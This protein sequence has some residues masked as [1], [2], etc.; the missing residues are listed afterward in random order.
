MTGLD[1]TYGCVYSDA[2]HCMHIHVSL[3]ERGSVVDLKHLQIFVAVADEGSI[4]A[5]GRKMLLSQPALSQAL[6]KLERRIGVTLLIRSP[7][8]VELTDS[9]VVFLEHCRAILS[10]IE[11]ALIDTRSRATHQLPFTV[12]LMAGRLSAG[13]LTNIIV[14]TFRRN[15]PELA[16]SIVELSF[17]D[18]V[19]AI[20]EKRVDV[21]IVR[22]PYE[23]P[24]LELIPLFS[25]P[26]MLCFSADHPLA[27]L[28]RPVLLA[29][30]LDQPVLR[31]TN[32]PSRWADYWELGDLRNSPAEFVTNPAVTVS[33]MQM[34][35]A[36]SPCVI[37]VAQSGWRMG[38][39]NPF[40]KAVPLDEVTPTQISVSY[41]KSDRTEEVESFVTCAKKVSA[42]MIDLVEGARLS[43]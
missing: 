6:R 22:P 4:H 42:E 41:L 14:T 23:E 43:A 21:A 34:G 40:L 8:G 31:L 18:Q 15:H 36:D 37:S 29:D 19:E 2:S 35:L 39:A 38:I 33:E 1:R 20:R 13:E 3:G 26:R 7:R 12:G 25:E 28:R 30:A 9:G 17:S 16:V 10:N 5:A 24:N 27:R 11:A 32:A